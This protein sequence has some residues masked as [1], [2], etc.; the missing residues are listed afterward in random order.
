M[1]VTDVLVKDFR[2]LPIWVLI[3]NAVRERTRQTFHVFACRLADGHGHVSFAKHLLF[4]NVNLGFIHKATWG[5]LWKDSLAQVAWHLADSAG[6]LVDVVAERFVFVAQDVTR[7]AEAT[8]SRGFAAFL[9]A[10][11][12]YP[13]F[14][15][16]GFS[17]TV[18]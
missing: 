11:E 7:K 16:S 8:E 3:V 5:F 9:G 4:P 18:K 17:E 6:F 13:F 2:A 12:D 1:A 14:F 15:G 10:N